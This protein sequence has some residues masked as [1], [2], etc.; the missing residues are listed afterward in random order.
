MST[1]SLLCKCHFV[2]LFGI[3]DV[4]LSTLLVGPSF[5]V[6]LPLGEAEARRFNHL[7]IT[8][9][10]TFQMFCMIAN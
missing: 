1:Y 10:Y 9:S 5:E 6:L 2:K 4:K 7:S 8:L 3:G